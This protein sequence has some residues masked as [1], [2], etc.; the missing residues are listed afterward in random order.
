MKIIHAAVVD[1]NLI[2][3]QDALDATA[4]HVWNAK[5]VTV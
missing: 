3:V 5:M 2:L 1:L 4:K